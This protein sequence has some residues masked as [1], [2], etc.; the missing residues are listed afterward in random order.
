M[1]AADGVEQFRLVEY[2][3]QPGADGA[4]KSAP[5]PAANGLEAT[6]SAQEAVASTA[7]Q[8]SA[9]TSPAPPGNQPRQAAP[10]TQN[11]TVASTAPQSEAD[12]SSVS[13]G[14][15]PKRPAEVALRHPPAN[16]DTALGLSAEAGDE[17]PD[18]QAL[19]TLIEA[20]S[21]YGK[22]DSMTDKHLATLLVHPGSH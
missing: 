21:A 9:E 18:A 1:Q 16:R 5:A 20:W 17:D 11:G 13:Q 8:P 2:T 4:N 3:S 19:K 22:V 10:S 12:T 15:P 6:P 14:M 7:L